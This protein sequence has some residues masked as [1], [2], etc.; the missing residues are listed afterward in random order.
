[1]PT[2][3]YEALNSAGKPQKGTV[4]AGTS[5]EAVQRIKGEG[6]FPTSVREQ[7]IKGEA[8]ARGA[9]KVRKKKKSFD[10]AITFGRVKNK[11]LTLFTRQLST[12][13]DAGLPLLRSLHV[14]EGQQRPGLMKSVLG[15]V[16]E[17]VEG[18]TAL[19]DAMAK[20]PK[21]FDRLYCKMVNAGEIGGV[22]DVILQRLANFLEKAQRLRRRIIGAMIYPVVVITVATVIVTGIMVFVIPKFQEIFNDFDVEL[23]GLTV[24]L[25]NISLWVAGQ[26]V[27]QAIPGAIWILFS[28]VLVWMFLTRWTP[29]A[30]RRTTRWTT[31]AARRTTRWTPRAAR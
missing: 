22:L 24:S 29:R 21:A 19:S 27:D 6:F 3:V 11:H 12:L 2:Y 15:Q 26:Q 18:G 30:A 20:H 4:D 10:L 17:D 31:R 7:K 16:A 13:Q 23:P 9:D 14:L 5:E 28:P 8:G 25:I 1:M